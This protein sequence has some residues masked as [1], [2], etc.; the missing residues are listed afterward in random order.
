MPKEIFMPRCCCWFLLLSISLTTA[1]LGCRSNDEVSHRIAITGS[2]TVAP[3]ISEIAARFEKN[4]PGIRIDVQTGGSSRG[5][6]DTREGRANF[7]MVSRK[8]KAEE[9]GF[10][11]HTLAID[12]IALI[13]HQSNPVSNLTTDQVNRIFRGQT[14]NWSEV[15]GSDSTITICSKAEG[16]GTLEV[17]LNHFKLAADEIKASIIVGEN[18]HAIKTVAGDP[19]A[20]TFVSVGSAEFSESTGQSIK[21]IALN[22]VVGSTESVSNGSYSLSRP[23]NLIFAGDLD[24]HQKE[25]LEFA[26]SSK[27]HDLILA[28]YFI[29]AQPKSR[30]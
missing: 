20:V 21:R 15:G 7:G 12:G 23:L 10:S 11:V 4:N 24:S 19:A 16:R 6:T 2:S 9:S 28:Q 13:A 8:L 26:M 25:F 14:T 18:Q 29:P 1:I 22:G 5:I 27:C 17:F 30:R 3:I